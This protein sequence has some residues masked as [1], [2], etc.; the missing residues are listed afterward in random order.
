MLRTESKLVPLAAMI[1][2]GGWYTSQ[3][4]LLHQCL[5]LLLSEEEVGQEGW[6]LGESRSSFEWCYVTH[7]IA[8]V[9][10][11]TDILTYPMTGNCASWQ[12]LIKA[13]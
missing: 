9:S 8:G 13:V 11:M 7:V 12:Y 3:C 6:S 1:F 10:R 4:Y 2:P 5:C